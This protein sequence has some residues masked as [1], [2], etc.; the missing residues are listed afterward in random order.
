MEEKTYYSLSPNENIVPQKRESEKKTLVY[1]GMDVNFNFKKT[2]V[3]QKYTRAA[4]FLKRYYFKNHNRSV[5][6]L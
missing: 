6:S 5:S 1:F 2:Y 3:R 4:R